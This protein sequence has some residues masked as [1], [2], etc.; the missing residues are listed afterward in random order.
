MSAPLTEEQVAN[1]FAAYVD[2]IFSVDHDKR[3]AASCKDPFRIILEWFRAH[4][5]NAT[6]RHGHFAGIGN[7]VEE[8]AVQLEEERAAHSKT[9]A[10]LYELGTHVAKVQ[11]QVV[12]LC[13]VV[14]PIL[15]VT[16][17]VVKR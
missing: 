3:M 16:A 8:L 6:A 13:D 1:E 4:E 7:A 17:N 12:G 2:D 5:R 15:G 9:L 10:M 14:T 11:H